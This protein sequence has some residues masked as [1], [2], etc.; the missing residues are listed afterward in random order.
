[1]ETET[2]RNTETL[3]APQVAEL[4]QIP[5]SSVWRA[6]RAGTIPHFRVG[7]RLVRFNRSALTEW[8]RQRSAAA[9]K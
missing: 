3:T 5:V 4:L 7:E 8:M 2:E 9:S 6:V 1:M